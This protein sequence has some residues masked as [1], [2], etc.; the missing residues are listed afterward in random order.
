MSLKLIAVVPAL[1]ISVMVSAQFNKGTRMVGATVGNLFLN[2]GSA[3]ISFPAPTQGYTSNTTSF[4][5]SVAP[6]MGWFLNERTVVGATLN[7]NPS[8]TKTTYENGGN[9]YQK[10]ELTS[11]N[12]GLGGFARNYFSSSSSFLPFGQVSVNGGITTQK[13]EGFFIAQSNVYKSTYTG[14]SSGGSFVNAAL[15][16][17]ITKLLNPHTGLDIFAGYNFSYTKTEYKTT[18]LRDD[19]NN[20]SVDFTS[21]NQPTTKYTNHGFVVGVGFQVFLF[22]K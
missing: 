9:T 17:G 18:T 8:H 16:L 21:I 20:G 10:D 11:F 12:I 5:L 1:W 13:T 15:T 4:G 7:L 22:S 19:G 3:D 14:K 2:S 6:S